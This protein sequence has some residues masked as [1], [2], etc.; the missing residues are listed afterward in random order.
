MNSNSTSDDGHAAS[1]SRR[2]IDV[3]YFNGSQSFGVSVSL[4]CEE[5]VEVSPD[6]ELAFI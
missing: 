5:R 1:L 6:M 4:R 2:N 3:K